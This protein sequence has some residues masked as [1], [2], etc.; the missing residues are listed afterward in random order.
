VPVRGTR[1]GLAIA[2]VVLAAAC[3]K[4]SPQAVFTEP[5]FTP[6]VTLAPSP[7]PTGSAGNQLQF[8]TLV[9]QTIVLHVNGFQPGENVTFTVTKPD[10][11]SFTGPPHVVAQDGT[12]EARYAPPIA[13]TYTVVAKGDRGGQSTS[14]FIVS[15]SFTAPQ[16]TTRTTTTRRRTSTPAPTVAPTAA[17]TPTHTPAATP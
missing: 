14:Q 11:S 7:T 5:P 6:E 12:T 16:P 1:A 17:P 13:G 10:G 4:G 8:Q 9:G 15:S 2:G 3:G